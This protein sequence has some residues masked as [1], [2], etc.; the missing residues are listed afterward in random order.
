MAC[1]HF[2]LVG[3]LVASLLPI[4]AADSPPVRVGDWWRV[5]FEEFGG[6]IGHEFVY[7]VADVRDGIATIGVAVQ[8]VGAAP[9]AMPLFPVGR[10][11]LSTLGFLAAGS[12]FQPTM[13]APAVGAAWRTEWA[14]IPLRAT[15][16]AI[17][18]DGTLITFRH[19]DGSD[20]GRIRV[21]ATGWIREHRIDGFATARVV[22]RGRSAD[23]HLYVPTHTRIVPWTD[24]GISAQPTLHTGHLQV[25]D[26]FDHLAVLVM[27]HAPNPGDVARLTIVGP[28]LEIMEASADFTTG[29]THTIRHYWSSSPRGLWHVARTT[30]GE[31][32]V[33]V[34]AVGVRHIMTGPGTADA[35][36]MPVGEDEGGPVVFTGAV[37][38]IASAFDFR[39][40]AVAAVGAGALFILA[41]RRGLFVALFVKLAPDQVENQRVRSLLLEIVRAQ[42]GLTTQRLRQEAGIAWGAATYHLQ[43][44][45]R[46]GKIAATNWGRHRHWFDPQRHSASDRAWMTALAHEPARRILDAMRERPGPR[47]KDL[48]ASVSLHRAT[49][50]YHIE[51]LE[52]LGLLERRVDQGAVRYFFKGNARPIQDG[53]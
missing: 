15:V 31:G 12:D 14:G 6:D 52:G 44:L 50:G 38:P 36:S 40:L 19:E 20:H 23:C 24:W 46:N 39:L 53:A 45:Q 35:C 33:G 10:V 8:D 1:R 7:A 26:D 29:A 30:A 43:V 41:L 37:V 22:D 4:A 3:L 25:E 18:E 34:F 2:L 27:A 11:D 13:E 5:E 49:V 32:D 28:S 9:F 51:K 16:A 17:A 47:Q 48:A 42:P 21:D